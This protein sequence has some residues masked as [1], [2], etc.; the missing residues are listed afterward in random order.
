[1]NYEELQTVLMDQIEMLNDNSI[2]EEEEKSRILVE[3]SRAINDLTSRMLDINRLQLETSKHKLE[4]CKFL[5]VSNGTYE[6]ELLK[7]EDK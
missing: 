2:M 3:R 5:E 4:V 1:M 6:K 7:L